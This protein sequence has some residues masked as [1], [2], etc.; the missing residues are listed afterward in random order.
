MTGRRSR[1][2]GVLELSFGDLR[3]QFVFG[4]VDGING[5]AG[6]VI[7][8]L[9]SSASSAIILTALTARA[10]S[11]AV[12][13]AGAQYQSDQ[14]ELPRKLRLGRVAA[15]GGGYLTSALLPGLGFAVGIE[16]GVAV[17]V[18]SAAVILVVIAW[19][20][21]RRAGWAKAVLTTLAIFAMAIGAGLLA[22]AVG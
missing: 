1:L 9:G 4:L 13:M 2:A 8:L 20:R 19:A 5:A 3:E 7:G 10:G 15:M 16:V 12:S 18:P 21:H 22:S 17:F 14:S 11:S 6:L